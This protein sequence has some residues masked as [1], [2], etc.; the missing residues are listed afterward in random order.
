MVPAGSNG[1][2]NNFCEVA[3]EERESRHPNDPATQGGIRT[4]GAWFQPLSQV[5]GTQEP[6]T[7][8]PLLHQAGDL[9]QGGGGGCSLADEDGCCK[10]VHAQHGL[11]IDMTSPTHHHFAVLLD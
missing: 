8:N 4:R 5:L 11:L 7:L 6:T 9:S 3:L 10:L 1:V 2:T